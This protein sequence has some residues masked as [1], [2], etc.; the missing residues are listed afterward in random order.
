MKKHILSLLMA[1]LSLSCSEENDSI[2]V[3]IFATD[4]K[5]LLLQVNSPAQ[6]M[7]LVLV[8]MDARQDVKS[9]QMEIAD[10][11]GRFSGLPYGGNFRIYARGFSELA[12]KPK[13]HFYGASQTFLAEEE[14]NLLVPIQVGQVDCMNVNGQSAYGP[15]GQTYAQD[16]ND[17]RM[18]ASITPLKDG[19]V[20]IMGGTEDHNFGVPGRV[21]NSI[22]IYDPSSGHLFLRPETLS[23]P[24]A[25]HSATLLST[26]EILIVGGASQINT[27]RLIPSP[28]ASLLSFDEQDQI[29]IQGVSSPTMGTLARYH[30][31]AIPLSDEFSSVLILGGLGDD[32]VP[33]ASALRYFPYDHIF[34]AQGDMGTPRAHFA[35]GSFGVARGPHQLAF[36]SGGLDA[37]GEL[38][39]SVDIFVTGSEEQRC[40]EQVIPTTRQGCFVFVSSKHNTPRWHHQAVPI[41]GGSQ[42][43]FVGGYSDV[44]KLK[45]IARLEIFDHEMQ[46]ISNESVG[47]LQAGRGELSATLLHDGNILVVGGG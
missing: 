11:Q 29:I 42:V 37:D 16:T 25:F 6:K 10:Q 18:G 9:T 38:L 23:T 3:E 7:E 21:L 31:Q 24:R 41:D 40:H 19:R 44:D 34:E 13:L 36:A 39:D 46:F 14:V 15:S 1:S 17:G 45:G 43:L 26:G 47:L 12:N 32:G 8:D 5:N 28:S 2:Q 33:L 35:G 20:L 30:H 27:G 4:G 22:E